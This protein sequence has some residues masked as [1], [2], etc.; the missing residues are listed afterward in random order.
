MRANPTLSNLGSYA[1]GEIQNRVRSMREA[2]IDL[3]DFSIGDPREPTPT[4]VRDA[5]RHAIPEVSQYPTVRGLPALREAIAGYVE[6][7]CGVQVDPDTQVLP[8]AGSKEAIFSTPLALID[9]QAGDAVVWP[10]PG[11][12][13]YERGALFAGAVGR[14]IALRDD[15][16]FRPEMVSEQDWHRSRMVWIC[17]PHNPAGSVMERDGLE[18][19]LAG[20][21]AN[22]ALLCSDEC[23]LDLY[24]AEPPTSVLEVAGPGARGALAF[25]SLSKRS[26]MTGY[27]SGAMV[28]DPEVI[29]LLG[30][31]RTSIGTASP[32]FVQAGAI[33]A[34][35]DDDH[36]LRRRE[37]FTAKRAILRGS[38]ERLGYE[39]VGSS[40]GIYLW[41]HV[42]DDVAVTERLLA[43]NIVVSPGR[44]FGPGGEGHIRL[45]LV[46]TLADCVQAGE[47]V[48]RCLSES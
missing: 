39:V 8:T 9:R 35:S 36:V 21:R 22:D 34:W 45:A 16:V 11:Y 24:E 43:A 18:G 2:G 27:R 30:S 42:G 47:A 12:P 4:A 19:F 25:F 20:A 41:V 46:P 23:Y 33:A 3:I 1:I 40:A 17:S 6:R 31:F 32:E 28:G 13:I 38:F 26:G 37:I 15:F 29:A 48:V 10:T 14:P 5:V 44:A 7:R